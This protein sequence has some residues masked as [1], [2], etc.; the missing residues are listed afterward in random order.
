VAAALQRRDA[1][2]RGVA[3]YRRGL[4]RCEL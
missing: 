2:E 1:W 3:A 4:R